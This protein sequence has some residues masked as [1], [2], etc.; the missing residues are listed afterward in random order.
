MSNNNYISSLN[1]GGGNPL[2]I[3]RIGGALEQFDIVLCNDLNGCISNLIVDYGGYYYSLTWNSDYPA[4][5]TRDITQNNIDSR[6]YC[7]VSA[8]RGEITDA[9]SRPVY[10]NA[11][12]CQK[13]LFNNDFGYNNLRPIIEFRE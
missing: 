5:K 12:F 4:N 8:V 7:L 2:N 11:H 1:G 13:N 6:Y 3:I 10:Y 9:L